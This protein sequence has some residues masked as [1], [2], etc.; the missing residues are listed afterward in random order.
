MFLTH[1][2]TVCVG[3]CACWLHCMQVLDLA[4]KLF[5]TDLTLHHQIVWLA[6]SIVY[7][8]GV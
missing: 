8:G 1:P 2:R 5:D 3:A 6:T 4:F 7:N